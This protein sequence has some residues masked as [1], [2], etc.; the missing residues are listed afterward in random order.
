[1]A[2]R[3][4]EVDGTFI[5]A[6]SELAAINMVLGAAASGARAMTSSSSPGVSLKQEGISYLAGCELP[7]VIVNIMRGGPG[8]GN[9]APAQS[10]Y[11]QAVKGGGH[12][13][14]HSIVLAPA[15]VQ[16][17]F[18]LTRSAFDLADRYRNPVII[19]GDG[20][21]GQM[22][23]PIITDYTDKKP[24]ITQIKKPWALMGC[25]DRK[26]NLIRSIY[27]E[28]GRLEEF[29][30][31]LQAKYK[32]IKSKEIRLQTL[33][34]DNSDLILVAYGLMARICKSVV[35]KLRDRKK[36]IGL[37]RPITLWPFPENIFKK[38]RATNPKLRA[39]LV[40]EMSAGQMVEDV[41]LA[42][43]GNCPVRFYG[44]TGGGIPT[45]EEIIEKITSYK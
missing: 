21:L 10:D 42:V 14:Y 36:R 38:L 17:M 30:R 37:I 34:L 20:F 25:K 43:E 29:N 27:L 40:V 39:I 45:E 11:F 7:A 1:M 2:R 6:E 41:R 13:D 3:M 15:G 33:Y 19:L 31:L 4:P 44:R 18:D 23:E 35:K 12:G 24:Q 16:E 5:Q 32:K 28:E 8:L 22:M 9:I 26:P